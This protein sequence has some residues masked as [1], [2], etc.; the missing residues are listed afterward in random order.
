MGV[1]LKLIATLTSDSTPLSDK[2]IYF[3][4]SF[5]GSTWTLIGSGTTD[6][7]GQTF[8]THT[9]DRTTYYKAVFEGD[10]DYESSFATIT[11]TLITQ[12]TATQTLIGLL[13]W[14]IPL[15]LLFPLLDAITKSIREEHKK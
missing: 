14:I 15:L 3:Y 10:P 4:Y 8:V 1:T 5:D 11:Y 7:N 12:P 2:T 6:V 13:M 9:T